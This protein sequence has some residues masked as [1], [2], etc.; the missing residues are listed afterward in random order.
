MSSESSDLFVVHYNYPQLAA[1]NLFLHV[2]SIPFTWKARFMQECKYGVCCLLL[3]D[4]D[5]YIYCVSFS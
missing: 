3:F 5:M 4:I 2:D 1:S